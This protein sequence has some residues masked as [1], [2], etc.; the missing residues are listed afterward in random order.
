MVNLFATAF[1]APPSR[2][3]CKHVLSFMCELI[4]KPTEGGGGGSEN[5]GAEEGLPPGGV[6]DAVGR[7][8]SAGSFAS[9]LS[10]E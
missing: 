8:D 2:C 10:F 9:L 7:S 4:G 6:P 1:L 5:V 3:A